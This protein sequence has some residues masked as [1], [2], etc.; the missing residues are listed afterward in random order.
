MHM[1]GEEHLVTPVLHNSCG[2]IRRRWDPRK[3]VLYRPFGHS[4]SVHIRQ[5]SQLAGI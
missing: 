5:T 2:L 1:Q 3:S 4:V